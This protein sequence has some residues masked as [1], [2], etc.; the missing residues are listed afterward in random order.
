MVSIIIPFVKEWPQVAFTIRSVAETLK[1]TQ[2]KILAIDNLQKN[3]G[4]DRAT[5]NIKAMAN[6]HHWLEYHRKNEK[7]SHWQCKNYGIKNSSGEILLFID[8]HCIAPRDLPLAIEY[9]QKN[10]E[11]LNGSMHLPLTYHILENKRLIYKAVFDVPR[12]DH[13]YTFHT[14]SPNEN[15]GEAVFEVPTMSTCGMMI[16]RSIIEKVGRWPSELGIYGGGEHFLNYTLAVMGYK[17]WIYKSSSALYHHG[18]KRGYSW[19]H[20][21]YQRNRAIATYMF[22]GSRLL[23]LWMKSTAKLRPNEKNAMLMNIIDTCC[24]HRTLIKSKQVKTVEEFAHE[25]KGSY[26]AKGDWGV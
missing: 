12:G 18:D 23:N 4:E 17:K 13:A 8:A 10:W 15:R 11:E 16:H 24:D 26:L 3:M 2:F 1:G 6:K 19:N 14:Y 25:W 22:G 21:D 20:H 9:Y 5:K 7:L